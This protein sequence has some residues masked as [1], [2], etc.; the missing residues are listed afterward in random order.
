MRCPP[1][2]PHLAW[3]DVTFFGDFRHLSWA[4][5]LCIWDA[6]NLAE[7]HKWPKPVYSP[8]V[9]HQHIKNSAQ[10]HVIEAQERHEKSPKKVTSN[11]A[12]CGSSGGLLICFTL[13]QFFAKWFI[14]INL[15]MQIFGKFSYCNRYNLHHYS[16][17]KYLHENNAITQLSP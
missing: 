8:K 6:I 10:L 17:T 3:V 9:W 1:E 16:L 15:L 14:S 12:R 2:E 11:H 7:Y 13:L 5:F 4:Y